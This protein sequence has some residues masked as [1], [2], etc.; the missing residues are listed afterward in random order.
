MTLTSKFTVTSLSSSEKFF[1]NSE[2]ND[3]RF[4]NKDRRRCYIHYVPPNGAPVSK[5][6][7]YSNRRYFFSE[8]KKLDTI[9]GF[10]SE[11]IKAT[12]WVIIVHVHQ[13]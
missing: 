10:L 2:N 3:L 6:K 11:K 9:N 4:L 8:E 13:A 12:K 7:A 1:I 5:I